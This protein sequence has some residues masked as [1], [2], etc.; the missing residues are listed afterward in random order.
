MDSNIWH[1][2]QDQLNLFIKIDFI[3]NLIFTN[4][5]ENTKQNLSVRHIYLFLMKTDFESSARSQEQSRS[6]ECTSKLETQ[7]IC[8]LINLFVLKS[9]NQKSRN[10]KNSW[11]FAWFCD[12]GS[13]WSRIWQDLTVVEYGWRGFK[14]VGAISALNRRKCFVS[15]RLARS[16][17][18]QL[19][20]CEGGDGLFYSCS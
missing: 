20:Y 14:H 9:L 3:R 16:L 5:F 10:I 11:I 18:T 6:A 17:S 13:Q 7:Q 2:L 12:P 15:A 1:D 19:Y 8:F 4:L